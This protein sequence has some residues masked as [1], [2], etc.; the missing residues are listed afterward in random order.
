MCLHSLSEVCGFWGMPKSLWVF[1]FNVR[2]I[3]LMPTGIGP[4]RAGETQV[5]S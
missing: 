1:Y 5:G 2:G 3:F 4:R